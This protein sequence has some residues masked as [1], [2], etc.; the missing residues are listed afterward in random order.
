M[1]YDK[2]I[3]PGEEGKIKVKIATKG[4]GGNRLSKSIR[5]ETNDPDHSG[6][7]LMI[8]GN[9]KTIATIVPKSVFLSGTAGKKI[10]QVV[11]IIPEPQ[12]S[13]KILNISAL[14]GA[15]CRHTLQEIEN[16]G[17]KFYELTVE[18]TKQTPGRYVDTITIITDRS[19][20]AP[21]SIYVRGQIKADT[22]GEPEGSGNIEAPDQN[23]SEVPEA[24]GK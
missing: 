14:N 21:L 5:V 1:S 8:T 10:S 13:F 3:P 9:V 20:Q 7:E 23:D 6:I 4:Y 15:D 2:V 19:D 17:N 11:R 24:E 22:G 12:E 18:N 16:F